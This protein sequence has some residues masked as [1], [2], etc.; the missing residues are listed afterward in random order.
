MSVCVSVSCNV[1]VLL[2]NGWMDLD[3]T[4][5]GLVP[6]HIV[7]LHVDPASHPPKGGGGSPTIFGPCLLW[8][9]GWVD[10]DATWY[11]GRPWPKPHCVRWGPNSPGPCLLCPIGRPCWALVR[12][13]FTLTKRF[14]IEGCHTYVSAVHVMHKIINSLRWH[15]QCLW[16]NLNLFGD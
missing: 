1:G 6:G 2:A 3:V 13:R 5:V 7:T 15:K 14:C 12:I 10:Q 11:G 8:S 16:I 4:V 9:N